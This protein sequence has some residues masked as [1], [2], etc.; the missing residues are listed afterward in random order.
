MVKKF[1]EI[2]N[3]PLKDFEKSGLIKIHQSRRS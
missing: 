2:Q 3:W 1:S